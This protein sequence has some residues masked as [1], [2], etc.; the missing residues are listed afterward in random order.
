MGINHQWSPVDDGAVKHTRLE[1][2]RKWS[3]LSRVLH[4]IAA[5]LSAACFQP[6]ER[7]ERLQSNSVYIKNVNGEVQK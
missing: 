7:A 1:E 5:A 6:H 2:T 4:N 3:L